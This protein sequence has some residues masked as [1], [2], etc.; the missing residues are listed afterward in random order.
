KT[1]VVHVVPFASRTGGYE[2][3]ARLLTNAQVRNKYELTIITHIEHPPQMIAAGFPAGAA[4][5]G[6]RHRRG[7][8]DRAGIREALRSHRPDVLHVHAL[9]PLAGAVVAEGRR[10]GIPAV[11]MVAS[12]GDATRFAAPFSHEV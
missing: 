6:I 7:W 10:L 4:A 8:F 9:D 2:R 3:Q 5:V 12:P 11:V 1:R